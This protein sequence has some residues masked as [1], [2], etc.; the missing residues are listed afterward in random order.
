MATPLHRIVAAE[1]RNRIRSGR[2]GVGEALPAE[3]EL[4]REFA[5]SRGPVRQALAAL[6]EEGLIGGGGQGRRSVVLDAVPAQPFESFL[7]FTRR[8]EL[9]GHVPGQRLQEIALRRPEPVVAAALQLEPDT[10]AVQLIRLRLLDGKPA[11]LERMSYV[12]SV[13]RLLLNADLDAGSIYALL[14]DQGVELHT[15]RHTFD[16]V[17]ADSRDAEL[18]GVALGHPLLRERRL[19]TDS[20]GMPL[21]WSDD[22]YRSDIATVTVTNTRNGRSGTGEPATVSPPVS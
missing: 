14:M 10:L 17:P 11:M 15:A 19:T 21:E 13:G 22:R 6:R 9:T 18:L 2:I 5:A 1:L 8:A 3:A 12:E 16:A 4:C 7:S 20:R